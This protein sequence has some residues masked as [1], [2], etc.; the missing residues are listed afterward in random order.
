MVSPSS[1]AKAATNTKPLTLLFF[2][3][4]MTTPA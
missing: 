3:L 1:G 4:A 2:V